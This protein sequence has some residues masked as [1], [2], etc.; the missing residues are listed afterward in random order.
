MFVSFVYAIPAGL[1]AENRDSIADSSYR[2]NF[3]S[4][5][6]DRGFEPAVWLFA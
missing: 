5:Y 4:V 1:V 6:I 2:K 3:H